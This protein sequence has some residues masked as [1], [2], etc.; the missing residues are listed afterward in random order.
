MIVFFCIVWFAIELSA[1]SF[2][3]RKENSFVQKR[4][5][6]A[7]LEE[8]NQFH[9]THEC[10]TTYHE[11][12]KP[13]PGALTKATDKDIKI[14]KANRWQCHFKNCKFSLA[15][16]K[17]KPK[18]MSEHVAA[19]IATKECHGPY[20][21][22]H[23]QCGFCGSTSP[24]C[25]IAVRSGKVYAK[26]GLGMVSKPNLKRLKG[27]VNSLTQCRICK[28]FHWLLNTSTHYRNRHPGQPTPSVTDVVQKLQKKLLTDQSIKSRKR[29]R[30]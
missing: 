24:Y 3:R 10:E 22:A 20:N 5:L 18:Q 26:C 30:N 1:A 29:K 13:Y 8:L 6:V 16:T 11:S 9:D 23:E 21:G 15:K 4:G 12:F 14:L 19:H 2:S 17:A 28:K 27:W 7:T 25:T